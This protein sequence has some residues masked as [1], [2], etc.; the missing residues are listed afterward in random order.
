MFMALPSTRL[1]S[2]VLT[3]TSDEVRGRDNLVHLSGLQFTNTEDEPPIPICDTVSSECHSGQSPTPIHSTIIQTPM[4]WYM[5]GKIVFSVM[6]VPH[7]TA[8]DNHIT[9]LLGIKD[10]SETQYHHNI[11][12]PAYAVGTSTMSVFDLLP[13]ELPLPFNH[14]LP[15][16]YSISGKATAAQTI[17]A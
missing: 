17:E 3:L 14:G 2:P 4:V 9:G 11:L 16:G 8:N 15:V 1:D 6:L 5:N 13:M 10:P 7:S 12:L